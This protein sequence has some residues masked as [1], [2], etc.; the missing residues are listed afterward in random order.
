MSADGV[1]GLIEKKLKNMRNVYDFN[2][3]M[4]A[5]ETSRKQLTA[6]ELNCDDFYEWRNE[7]RQSSRFLLKNVVSAT[8]QRGKRTVQFKTDFSSTEEFTVDFLKRN[9]NVN[10]ELPPPTLHPR[11]IHPS[12]KRGIVYHL[13]PLMPHNKRFFL[14][15][16]G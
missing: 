2:D 6:V 11:G 8:F 10:K 7:R 15:K 5:V 4:S 9:F 1:H 16:F 13:C 12:K 14:G 3:Y